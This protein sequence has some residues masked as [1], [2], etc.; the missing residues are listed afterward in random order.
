MK[1]ML[2]ASIVL[3][4]ACGVVSAD[5]LMRL[6]LDDAATLGTTIQSDPATKAEAEKLVLAANGPR[7]FGRFD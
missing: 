3:V 1:Y 5:E 6:D 7:G 2:F 4:V